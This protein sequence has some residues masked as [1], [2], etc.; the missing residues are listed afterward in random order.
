MSKRNILKEAIDDAKAL[1]EAAYLNAKSVLLENMKDSIKE[2]VDEQLSEACEDEKGEEPVM[3][4]MDLAIDD[5][6]DLGD[7]EG[8]A[9]ED[10]CVE[11]DLTEEDLSEAISEALQALD[12]IEHAPHG[13]SE[14]VDKEHPSGGYDG[15]MK[16]GEHDWEEE[17]PPAK[18]DHSVKESKVLRKKITDLVKENVMLKKANKKLRE[19]VDEIRL[20]NQKIMYTNKLINKEGLSNA[21]KK[22]IVEKMD[23][24]KSLSEAKNI[25]EAFECTLGTLSESVKPKKQAAPALSEVLGSSSAGKPV[26]RET[27][28][29]ALRGGS[30]TNDRMRKLAGI[31]KDDE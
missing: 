30:F 31:S 3:E 24:A 2:A 16:A 21:T 25:F 26:N 27:L 5:E 13:E 6:L 19:S 15:D 11:D 10:E 9:G 7:D 20:F 28:K 1:K 14:M 12:E 4:N 17:V 23:S 18:K 29:E 8:D 22:K